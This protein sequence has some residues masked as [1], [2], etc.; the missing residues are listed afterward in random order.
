[1]ALIILHSVAHSALLLTV[2]GCTLHLQLALDADFELCSA[3]QHPCSS[4]C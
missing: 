3:L 4:R 2:S 1:M